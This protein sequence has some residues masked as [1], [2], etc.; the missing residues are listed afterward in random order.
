M[1]LS[2]K[3]IGFSEEVHQAGLPR[4]LL[5]MAFSL[6]QRE[7]ALL[8]MAAAQV[9][10]LAKLDTSF[11][12][13]I[14]ALY[15]FR[16]HR[17]G[18][19]YRLP[20][21]WRSFCYALDPLAPRLFDCG[22]LVFKGTEPLS[23]AFHELLRWMRTSR[24]GENVAEHLVMVEGKVP[25]A[26]TETEAVAEFQIA[27]AVHMAHSRHYGGPAAMPVPLQVR[28][29]PEHR[30]RETATALIGVLSKPALER[31]ELLI[32]EGLACLVQ[33]YPSAPIRSDSYAG[34]EFAALAKHFSKIPEAADMIAGWLRLVARLL[35]LGYLP[36]TVLS[37]DFG[38]C[39]NGQNATID[40][41]FCDAGSI[42]LIAPDME[43]EFLRR[44][45][46]FSLEC[47][48]DAIAFALT[49]VG[50]KTK[51]DQFR[52]ADFLDQLEQELDREAISGRSLPAFVRCC[53]DDFRCAEGSL[54]FVKL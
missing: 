1:K 49:R 20:R 12:L 6:Q 10:E 44:S 40:G 46:L 22:V 2:R 52:K 35:W 42:T 33:F 8:A 19:F 47:L 26:V 32:G 45:L 15:G 5:P 16:P 24:P 38:S 37:R 18:P 39:L 27:E 34:S 54:L 4:H 14:P 36:A 53:L 9:A 7:P 41:G 23:P 48:F 11:A 51:C 17:I 43:V 29:I 13:G 30:A 28:R 31:A 50:P 3:N 25:G 21:H